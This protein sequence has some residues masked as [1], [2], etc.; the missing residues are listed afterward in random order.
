ME[1]IILSPLYHYCHSGIS[2]WHMIVHY[3]RMN[4]EEECTYKKGTFCRCKDC[5]MKYKYKRQA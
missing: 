1:G 5:G 4:R 3:M 2:L